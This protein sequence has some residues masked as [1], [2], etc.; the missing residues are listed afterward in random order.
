MRT[1]AWIFS[2]ELK[3]KQGDRHLFIIKLW[4]VKQENS[5][6]PTDQLASLLKSKSLK[7]YK[8]PC[9][10]TEVES[11]QRH[12]IIIPDLYTHMHTHTFIY[13]YKYI[14]VHMV[15]AKITFKLLS[16]CKSDSHF[17]IFARKNCISQWTYCVFVFTEV[18]E[19]EDSLWSKFMNKG[20]IRQTSEQYK[21][22]QSITKWLNLIA[23]LLS[24][25][26]Y[27]IV[28]VKNI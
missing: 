9:L 19:F 23:E 21:I 10:K 6:K 26:G 27:L 24:V 18:M 2:T 16:I 11:D 4:K 22:V 28:E 12:K 17:Q 5:L 15:S 1:W 13:K 7:L 25:I 20:L 8:G 14:H 3:N